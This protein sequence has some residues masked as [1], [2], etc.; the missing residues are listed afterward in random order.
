MFVVTVASSLFALS[1]GCSSGGAGGNTE[2]ATI[3]PSPLSLPENPRSL[4]APPQP[5][6][7]ASANN[8]RDLANAQPESVLDKPAARDV[9]LNGGGAQGGQPLTY[10]ALGAALQKLGLTHEDDKTYWEMKVKATTDDK[11]DWT[12]PIDVSL[13]K[14][15]SVV[16]IT[17]MLCP[18]D[19]NGTPTA[20]SLIDLLT[21]NNSLGTSCFALAQ[22]HTLFLQQP[23]PNAGVTPEILGGN[24]KLY[25]TCMKQTEPLFKGF[26]GNTSGGGGNPFQ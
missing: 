6:S 5:N 17:C 20:Q 9:D 18:I 26:F 13:S 15:Q 14:D 8:A 7:P 2:T 22:N 23:F 24:L 1:A 19:K 10:A 16:W 12:F 21:A 11:I 4:E 25:F 3:A